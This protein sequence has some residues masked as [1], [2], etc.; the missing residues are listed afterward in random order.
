MVKR[1]VRLIA[2]QQ[3]KT[4]PTPSPTQ[5]RRST[6]SSQPPNNSSLNNKNNKNNNNQNNNNNS[7][8]SSSSN[9]KASGSGTTSGRIQMIPEV[10]IEVDEL[11]EDEEEDEESS[12][13]EVQAY[14]SPAKPTQDTARRGT[15]AVPITA[16][17]EDNE[18]LWNEALALKQT[19]KQ[20]HQIEKAQSQKKVSPQKKA[21]TSQSKGK[22][23]AIEKSVEENESSEE[24]EDEE[25]VPAPLPPKRIPTL[26]APF[27]PGQM[28]AVVT[29]NDDE[30]IDQL[31]EVEEEVGVDLVFS[32]IRGGKNVKDKI[33]LYPVFYGEE[34]DELYITLVVSQSC[35]LDCSMLIFLLSQER[36]AELVDTLEE[37]HFA[38]FP[39][40]PQRDFE[41]EIEMARN[42]SKYSCLNFLY[43]TL[44][45]DGNPLIQIVYQFEQHG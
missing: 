4:I 19:A 32:R 6:R 10:V 23:R 33:W 25:E 5:P 1:P 14:L 36:G 35:Y 17:D 21:S 22:G 41:R 13:F 26:P 2:S 20:Q 43:S 29:R 18:D 15:K 8:K 44:D 37:A 11:Q 28:L 31:E 40:G 9:A 42:A 16:P 34:R 24:E 39:R 12:D 38:L 30:Q 27:I 7:N 3:S 45:T